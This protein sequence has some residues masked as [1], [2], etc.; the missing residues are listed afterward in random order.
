MRFLPVS[1]TTI[2]VELAD[3]DETLALFAAL[4]ADPIDGIEEMV[5]AARTLMIRFRPEKVTAV[6]L[7]AR[8]S[9]R[10][11]SAKVA[12]SEHLVEIPVRYDGEDL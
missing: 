4:T 2:L 8:I 6:D 7:S 12:P 1:L 5:P 10:D 9:T 3:L 11:L